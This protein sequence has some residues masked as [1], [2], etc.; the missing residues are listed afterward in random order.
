MPNKYAIYVCLS[1]YN[2]TAKSDKY[3]LCVVCP[4]C[5]GIMECDNADEFE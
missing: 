2:H 3:V 5:G 4:F 1:N